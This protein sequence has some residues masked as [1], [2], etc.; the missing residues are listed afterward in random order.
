MVLTQAGEEALEMSKSNIFAEFKL[1]C[2]GRTDYIRDLK[3]F[4][5]FFGDTAGYEFFN[6]GF[7]A[8]IKDEI[9]G[10][11]WANTSKWAQDRII[12]YGNC[13]TQV[14][15]AGRLSHYI[16]GDHGLSAV[17]VIGQLWLCSFG[18]A[19]LFTVVVGLLTWGHP[20]SE[21]I[22][23]RELMYMYGAPKLISAFGD[24]ESAL[25]RHA[26]FRRLEA[27]MDVGKN[28]SPTSSD[29]D[30]MQD[31]AQDYRL[32]EDDDSSTLERKPR[33][34]VYV[35]HK[36]KDQKTKLSVWSLDLSHDGDQSTD[37]SGFS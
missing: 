21:F 22:A 13:D 20:P 33:R 9:S 24:I 36:L 16:C 3:E 17:S 23:G 18:L 27:E 25:F 34:N 10:E 30:V 7:K 19:L 1:Q 6:E 28:L 35:S 12:D 5:L 32:M 37:S 31:I 2:P 26:T 15:L 14:A 11:A 29:L 8:L 4:N